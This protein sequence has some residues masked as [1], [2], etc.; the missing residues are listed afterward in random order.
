MKVLVL[1]SGAGG[2]FPQWNCSCALCAGQR[3]G[4]LRA[5][6]RTQSS[7]AVSADGHAW[8]L[9]NA[10]PDIAQQIRARPAL[11]P[12]HGPRD[13]P[14]AAIVLT[15]AHID[16]V[17]GL[18][19]LRQGGPLELYATPGVFEHLTAGLPIL[20]VLQHYCGVHW[21]LIPVAGEHRAARFA[22]NGFSTLQFEA[23]AVA[24]KSPP[25]A[26]PR[27]ETPVGDHIALR[28]LD[29]AS[30]QRLF[31]APVLARVGDDE[32]EAMRDADC[33]LVDGSHWREDEMI[34]AGVGRKRASDLGH[35]ALA[36]GP[37]GTPG[38]MDVLAGLPAARKLLIHVNNTNPVLDETSPEHAE[39]AR[40][41]IE[42]AYDGMEI[43]L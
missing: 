15:D 34:A 25:Y 7:V 16:G 35:L 4:R 10:S 37:A 12:R 3:S 23:V 1:G 31:Y 40:R 39:L 20:P 5:A 13:T 19:S 29:S 8:V 30:G 41:G 28:I 22:V 33:L 9:L 17:S 2:G 14:I 36:G 18:L 43:E 32:V 38:M 27:S 26:T 42:V 6:P 11:Q 24:G 21:H